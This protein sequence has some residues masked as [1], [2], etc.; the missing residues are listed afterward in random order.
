MQVVCVGARAW[1]GL[2]GALTGSQ[3][4]LD[5]LEP[6]ARNSVWISHMGGGKG[7][8]YLGHPSRIFPG[9][10]AGSRADRL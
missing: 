2:T 10:S 9:T 5:Q 4:G 7:P 6:G 3:V 8:E 1:W